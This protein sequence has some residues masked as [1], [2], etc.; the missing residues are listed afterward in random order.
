MKENSKGYYIYS[1]AIHIHSLYSDGSKSIPEIAQIA[2]ELNIDYLLLADHNTL[3]GKDKGEERKYGST[4]VLIGYE[5]NDPVDENLNHYLAFNLEKTLPRTLTPAE[6]VRQVKENGGFGFIAHPHEFRSEM[7]KGFPKNP[8]VAWEVENFDGIEI[9]NQMSEWMERLPYYN[10]LWMAISP[11]KG[12]YHPPEATLKLWDQQNLKRKVPGIG[13]I[14]VHAMPYKIGPFKRVFFQYKIQF[15][16]IRTNIILKKPLPSDFNQAKMAIYQ[17][18]REGKSYIYNQRWGKINTLCTY[19][20]D[21]NEI[22]PP[23]S[24]LKL[25]E[26]LKLSIELPK[27]GL[28]KI[29]RNGKKMEQIKSKTFQ[30]S[31]IKPGNY[32]IEVF[33]KNHG[34]LYTNN[35]YIN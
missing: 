28:I 26:N 10:K 15:Q 6:Y 7:I 34:W 12:I 5:I 23:G 24:C 18:L 14:D 9:W 1:G 31:V 35:F 21:K 13:G 25:S 4:Y 8:W 20:Q 16:S 17:A 33:R 19:M 30:Y 27:K 22:H 2:D 11:R 32:R 29:L 3:A